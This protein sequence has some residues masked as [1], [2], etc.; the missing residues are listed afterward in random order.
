MIADRHIMGASPH[1]WRRLGQEDYLRGAKLTWKNYQVLSAEWEHE[2]CALLP[3]V[4]I[5][6][7]FASYA[8]YV[9]TVDLLLRCNAFPEPTFLCWDVRPQPRL[10]TVELRI[11]DAQTTGTQSATLAALVAS[12]AHLE[13]EEGYH[14]E[15]LIDAPE[16]PAENRFLAARDRMQARLLDPIAARPLPATELLERLLEAARPHAADLGCADGLQS[17]AALASETGAE[18]Q[19]RI[20]RA[21][22]RLDHLVAC[23]SD[24]FAQ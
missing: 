13:L 24:A 14:R 22:E 19:L 9:E 23:I 6:R 17:L 3:R 12:I 4:G 10:G 16:L 20:A 5:P 15:E 7:P 18:R 11:T 21:D 1:D 8:H 2:H